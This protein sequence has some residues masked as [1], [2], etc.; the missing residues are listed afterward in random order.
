MTAQ[1]SNPKNLTFNVIDVETANADRR[2]I[3]EIGIVYVEDGQVRDE[4]KTLIDPEDW[5]DPWNVE[6]HGI[7]EEVVKGSPTLP[8]IW[9]DLSII[10][11]LMTLR[12]Q[13]R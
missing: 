11:H 8:E 9:D 4:W 1:E 7:D 10:G 2:T 5:F 6:V 13:H 3:C 12:R